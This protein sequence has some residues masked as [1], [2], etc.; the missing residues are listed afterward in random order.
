MVLSL[1]RLDCVE[2][3][4]LLAGHLIVLQGGDYNTAQVRRGNVYTQRA[5]CFMLSCTGLHGALSVS[6]HS[7]DSERFDA[8]PETSQHSLPQPQGRR[9]KCAMPQQTSENCTAVPKNGLSAQRH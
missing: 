1:Q 5:Q 4:H 2:D 7:A 9:A 3:K 8:S 6:L